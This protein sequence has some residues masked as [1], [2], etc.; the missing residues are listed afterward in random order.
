MLPHRNTFI[1]VSSCLVGY[2]G[3]V[4]TLYRYKQV[5]Y[6]KKKNWSLLILW[7]FLISMLYLFNILFL[8]NILKIQKLYFLLCLIHIILGTLIIHLFCKPHLIRF[9]I[10]E[11]L[12]ALYFFF[13][14]LCKQ[15]QSLKDFNN[16]TN[17]LY[18][19]YAIIPYTKYWYPHDLQ[20]RSKYQLLN[21]I[22]G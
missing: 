19:Y 15:K 8:I 22:I 17:T 1:R 14:F 21:K 7:I 5:K 18:P 2:D 3:T 9:S 12:I 6:G 13:P 11:F 20:K 4:F 16:Q 10:A